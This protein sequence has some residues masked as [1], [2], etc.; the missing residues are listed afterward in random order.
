MLE[1]N[2]IQDITTIEHKIMGEYVLCS[3]AGYS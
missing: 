3:I 2:F 1:K